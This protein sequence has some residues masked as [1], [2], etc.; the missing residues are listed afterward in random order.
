MWRAEGIAHPDRLELLLA[1]LCT[2]LNRL[3]GGS[4]K[5]EDFLP[6]LEEEEPTEEIAAERWRASRDAMMALATATAK[7]E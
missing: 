6:W 4:A 5:L 7:K 2:G 3:A 1:C